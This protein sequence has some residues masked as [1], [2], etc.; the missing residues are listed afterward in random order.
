MVKGF[1]AV[2]DFEEPPTYAEEPRQD[3]T[4]RELDDLVQS[5]RSVAPRYKLEAKPV[6]DQV[7]VNS[8]DLNLLPAIEFCCLE[9]HLL[10]EVFE[11]S[12]AGLSGVVGRNCRSLQLY[13][14]NW[15]EAVY[16]GIKLEEQGL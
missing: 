9:A 1:A 13:R 14:Q 16:G 4:L 8:G 5:K 2:N 10:L 11:P 3:G 15:K 7:R 6:L 12:V